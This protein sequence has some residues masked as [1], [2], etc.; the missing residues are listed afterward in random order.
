MLSLVLIE[1]ELR[2]LIR[3]SLERIIGKQFTKKY[4]KNLEIALKISVRAIA[5]LITIY[6]FEYIKSIPE[7]RKYMSYIFV[8]LFIIFVYQE[9]K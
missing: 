3:N 1:G 9:Y 7:M 4:N 2:S 5:S 8:S 6:M